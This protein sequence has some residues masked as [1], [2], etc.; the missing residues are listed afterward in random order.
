MAFS[1]AAKAVDD[2]LVKYSDATIA[3]IAETRRDQ[4]VTK[5]VGVRYKVSGDGKDDCLAEA[6]RCRIVLYERKDD[7]DPRLLTPE[8]PIPQVL[9]LMKEINKYASGLVRIVAIADSSGSGEP[10][11]SGY[12]Y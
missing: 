11:Y 9:A 1:D 6:E 10:R 7:S 12:H 5:P 4:A 2:A 3:T 8:P